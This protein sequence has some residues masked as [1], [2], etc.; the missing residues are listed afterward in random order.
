MLRL[1]LFFLCMGFLNPSLHALNDP[2]SQ[3][4]K[5][6]IYVQ[7]HGCPG[8]NGSQ[9]RPYRTLAE[10]EADTSWGKL[11]VL[12]SPYPLDGG[13]TLRPGT[14]LIGGGSNP[15][16]VP[17]AIDQ[18]TI[19]N[20]SSSSNGGNGV[21]VTGNASI[22]NI[23]FKNVWASAIRYDQACDLCV[24]NVLITGNNQGN[25][26][27]QAN[28]TIG[29]PEFYEVA[30]IHGQPTQSGKT[31]LERVIIRNGQTGSGIIEQP[32]QG[33][34]RQLIVESCE[35]SEINSTTTLTNVFPVAGIIADPIGQET[36][37]DVLIKNSYLHDFGSQVN[38]SAQ[39]RGIVLATVSGSTQTNFITGCTLY[40]IHS[41]NQMASFHLLSETNDEA[42][43]NV[44]A[45]LKLRVEACHFEEPLENTLLQVTAIQNETTNGQTELIIKNSIITNVFDNIVSFLFGSGTQ[46]E[47][48]IG[49]HCSGYDSFYVAATAGSSVPFPNPQRVT[50]TL[51][52]DNT[53]T[54]GTSFGAID[55]IAN[56]DGG[57]NPWNNLTINAENNCFT[58]MGDEGV[59]F[60]GLDFGSGGAGNATIH[61]H[62]NSIVG[63][64]DISDQHANIN[65]FAQMNWWGPGGPCS[66]GCAPTQVCE[67]GVCVGPDNVVNEGT[68][69]VDVSD[70]LTENTARCICEALKSS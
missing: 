26:L 52:K 35:I 33:A 8:G 63:F 6:V 30:A 12:P 11:V 23:Y 43:A 67:E 19:T 15:T 34:L 57:S 66:S 53:F 25:V 65:Y 13:I 41:S 2:C 64:F 36:R 1:G 69:V 50:E 48:I 20:T 46:K 4:S 5:K 49:N 17:L 47:T 55:V 24:K 51:I 7:A 39:N 42:V 70:P 29:S 16:L 62:Q 32:Y 37:Q 68:G 31:C 22:E 21:V 56:I 28:T 18:P 44:S 38:T 27:S 45:N 3:A 60:L 9:K 40:K 54:G 59:A 61:A 58:G 10:A 14:K